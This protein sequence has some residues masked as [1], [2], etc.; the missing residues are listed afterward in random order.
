MQLLVVVVAGEAVSD[1]EDLR[2]DVFAIKSAHGW[3]NVSHDESVRD[4]SA[5]F[6]LRN[7]GVASK[8]L[9]PVVGLDDMWSG[10]TIERA[11]L[12]LPKVPGR[13]PDSLD[14]RFVRS[15]AVRG[16]LTR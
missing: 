9:G 4:E 16:P 13:K 11:Y 6:G 12:E 3:P 1:L 14:G 8:V 2:L 7:E 5:I 15:Q 10:P